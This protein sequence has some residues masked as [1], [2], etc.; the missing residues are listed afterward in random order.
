[1]DAWSTLRLVW[2]AA[3]EAMSAS[4]RIANPAESIF[5]TDMDLV[6]VDLRSGRRFPEQ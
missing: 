6:M 3:K 5:A 2:P 4:D 1:M